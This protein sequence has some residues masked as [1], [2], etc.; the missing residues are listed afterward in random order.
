MNQGP[1]SRLRT[2]CGASLPFSANGLCKGHGVPRTFSGPVVT[3]RSRDVLGSCDATCCHPQQVFCAAEVEERAVGR[4]SFA[5]KASPT[6]AGRQHSS[7]P[8]RGSQWD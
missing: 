2:V 5:A 6:T 7:C 1:W 3:R 8:A 4:D